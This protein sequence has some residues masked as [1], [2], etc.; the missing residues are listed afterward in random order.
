MIIT[1]I[2]VWSPWLWFGGVEYAI[3]YTGGNDC[4]IFAQLVSYKRSLYGLLYVYRLGEGSLETS[5]WLDL[6]LQ[7]NLQT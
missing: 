5:L 2:C 3:R 6:F 4:C 1:M 7:L